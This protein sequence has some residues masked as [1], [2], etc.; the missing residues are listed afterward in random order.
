MTNFP[1]AVP[2]VFIFVIVLLVVLF[3]F[4]AKITY[5]TNEKQTFYFRN[6]FPYELYYQKR[7]N[8]SSYCR[9]VLIILFAVLLAGICLFITTFRG[10]SANLAYALVIGIFFILAYIVGLVLFMLR[11]NY[12]SQFKLYATLFFLFTSMSA[13]MVG[14][15]SLTSIFAHFAYKVIG[16]FSFALM[17]LNIILMLNPKLKKWDRLDKI[18]NKDGTITYVRPKISPLAYSLWISMLSLIACEILCLIMM[19]ISSLG[20]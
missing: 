13:G 17:A 6:H 1:F 20:Y 15:V 19:L 18:T 5:H 12:L 3:V 16:G 11:V 2:L 10:A 7:L 14:I 9:L 8:I 4:T